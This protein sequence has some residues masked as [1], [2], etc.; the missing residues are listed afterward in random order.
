[1]M[2]ITTNP[3]PTPPP[4]AFPVQMDTHWE[5]E[6]RVVWNERVHAPEEQE[7]VYEVSKDL[8]RSVLVGATALLTVTLLAA[9][10]WA[11]TAMK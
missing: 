4:P 2:Y 1:M 11:V 6:N 8:V 3:A 7:L 9:L 10:I 5:T